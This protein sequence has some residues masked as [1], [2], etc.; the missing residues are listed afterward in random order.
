MPTLLVTDEFGAAEFRAQRPGAG[1]L[2]SR[3]GWSGDCRVGAGSGGT[4]DATDR[5]TDTD[6]RR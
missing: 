6:E 2:S 3:G 4:S 1:A 5:G